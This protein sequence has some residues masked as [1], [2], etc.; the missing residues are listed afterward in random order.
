[1]GEEG[2]LPVLAAQHP[3]AQG[4]TAGPR[5]SQGQM[6]PRSEHLVLEAAR[7]GQR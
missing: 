1:M 5:R 3:C 4:V 2:L 7:A 6:S